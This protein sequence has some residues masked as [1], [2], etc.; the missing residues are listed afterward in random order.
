[1]K[2]NNQVM[3]LGLL[4][5]L[6]VGVA[7]CTSNQKTSEDAS[8][9]VKYY[10]QILFSETAFDDIK[11]IHEINAEEAKTINNYKFTYDEK[12]RP[13]TIEYGRGSILLGN[14][15]TDATKIAI[16]YTDSSETRTYFDKDTVPQVVDG[17]VFK[18][19]F[20]LDANGQRT[21]LKF[22]GKDGT[23]IENRNKIASYTWTKLP[24]GMIKENRYNMAGTEVVMNPFCPFFELRFTYNE[25]GHVTRMANYQAD[26]L[27]NCT[28]EN[29]GDIGVS[30]F[31]FKNSD[32]GD[33]LEFSVHNTTGR[34]S[35]LFWGWA[36]FV[37]TVD[38]VGN[39][40][41][42]AYW[43]QDEEYLS[44]KKVPVYQYKYDAHGAK[45]ETSFLDSNRNLINH[46][47]SGVAITEYAYNEL[48]QPT[49]TI[50]Y[51]NKRVKL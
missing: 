23:Q 34:Y 14:A 22:Y 50:K 51:D 24:D 32:K 29:C 15:S 18:S 5:L 33:L 13:V 26:T 8:A 4:A 30:Y 17:D 40:I 37:N 19:V 12:Q 16:A 1:M 39:V 49:D 11:G 7:S 46:P 31:L 20:S 42:T 2:K 9:K 35:N 45:I 36:K 48:G 28:A 27:Y 44:G 38:S 47:Q 6:F 21:G 3:I 10:R 25:K 43:D 41:E